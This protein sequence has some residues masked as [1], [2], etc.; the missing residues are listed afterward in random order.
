[1]AAQKITMLP[2]VGKPDPK[3]AAPALA[4]LLEARIRRTLEAERAETINAC[5]KK[6]P[7]AK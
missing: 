4:R 1:M 3:T 6:P 2:S 5:P 7:K